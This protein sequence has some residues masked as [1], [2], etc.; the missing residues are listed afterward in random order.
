MQIFIQSHS[1]FKQVLQRS[2]YEILDDNIFIT[3]KVIEVQQRNPVFLGGNR[4][5]NISGGVFTYLA[6]RLDVCL[7]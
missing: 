3:C 4:P 2:S 5:L 7:L 1:D 6:E